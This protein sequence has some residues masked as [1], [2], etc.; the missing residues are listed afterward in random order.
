MFAAEFGTGQVFWSILW[1]ALFFIWIYLV[2]T[3]FSDIMRSRDMGSV[4][5]VIWS[6]FIIVLPYLGVFVYLIARGGGMTERAVR[7]QQDAEEVYRELM[8]SR[9]PPA[10]TAADLAKLAELHDQGKLTDEEFAALK[11]KALA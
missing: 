11:A 10:T 3:V 7:E 1:F 5:K 8:A 9:T 2:L 6:I 4:A